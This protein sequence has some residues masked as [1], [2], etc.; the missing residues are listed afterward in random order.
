MKG[1]IHPT[2]PG[3]SFAWDWPDLV[4]AP[5]SNWAHFRFLEFAVDMDRMTALLTFSFALLGY[6]VEVRF[7]LPETEKS[8]RMKREAVMVGQGRRESFD[9]ANVI[10]QLKAQTCATEVKITDEALR[11]LQAIEEKNEE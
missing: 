10:E 11:Q 8:R 7:P 9:L 3:I 6:Y 4:N 1:T 5:H 2:W